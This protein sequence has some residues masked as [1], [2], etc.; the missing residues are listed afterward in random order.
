MGVLL[1]Q[2]LVTSHGAQVP[3]QLL[4]GV[5][6][7]VVALI[8]EVDLVVAAMGLRLIT[9][10]VTRQPATAP[11]VHARV[12]PPSMAL[13]QSQLLQVP[14]CRLG[15]PCG[16]ELAVLA[17]SACS[18]NHLVVALHAAVCLPAQQLSSHLGLPQRTSC[19]HAVAC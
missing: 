6:G 17:P 2:A 5:V 14:G 13:L 1:L 3:Q 4:Q 15:M 18:H 11:T 9:S 10:L 12:L 7:E 16:T 19:A 8:S